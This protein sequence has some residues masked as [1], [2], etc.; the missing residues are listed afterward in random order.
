MLNDKLIVEQESLGVHG[1]D[2]SGFLDDKWFSWTKC[3]IAVPRVRFEHG[4]GVV[5]V[6]GFIACAEKFARG[7]VNY[8]GA[9]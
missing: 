2:A 3:Q 4:F 1:E 6:R 8:G 7:E 9:C 5:F